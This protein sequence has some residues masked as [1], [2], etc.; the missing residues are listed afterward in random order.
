[1][2]AYIFFFS[3]CHLNI[4]QCVNCILFI[5]MQNT[6]VDNWCQRGVA[7]LWVGSHSSS[8][9]GIKI[10]NEIFL[11]SVSVFLFFFSTYICIGEFFMIYDFQR[12]GWKML[13]KKINDNFL[14]EKDMYIGTNFIQGY[15]VKIADQIMRYQQ[16]LCRDLSTKGRTTH[17]R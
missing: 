10:E 16:H 11:S 6:C 13:K 3:N 12:H 8:R 5:I 15:H 1:M 9:H 14:F 7:S 2:N 4:S 17:M